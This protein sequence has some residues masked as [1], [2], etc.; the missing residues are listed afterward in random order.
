MWLPTSAVDQ[1]LDDCRRLW[2][3]CDHDLVVFTYID[4]F[5]QLAETVFNIQDSS[6]EI[7][8][9]RELKIALLDYNIK[10]EREKFEQGTFECGVCLEP[11]KGTVCYRLLRCSHVFCVQCLQDFYNTCISEG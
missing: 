1:L 11:K 6:G 5:Q 7:C 9:S 4:H 8:L 2:E 3:E 10:A